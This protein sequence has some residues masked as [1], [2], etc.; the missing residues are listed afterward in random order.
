MAQ[1]IGCLPS[2]HSALSPHS[3]NVK[4]F[5]LISSSYMK[6]SEKFN[7]IFYLTQY[8]QSIIRHS[9]CISVLPSHRQGLHNRLLLVATVLDSTLLTSRDPVPGPH[10]RAMAHAHGH[11]YLTLPHNPHTVARHCLEHGFGHVVPHCCQDNVWLLRPSLSGF[12]F[13]G[14]PSPNPPMQGRWNDLYTSAQRCPLS[15]T[16]QE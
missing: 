1:V 4:I 10:V 7:N 11:L 3:N 8:S 14:L 15:Q 5:F 2:K 6:D 16:L 12:P 13:P 9:P